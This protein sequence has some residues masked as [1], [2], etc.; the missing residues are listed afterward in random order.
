MKL[1]ILI[2]TLSFSILFSGCQIGYLLHVSYNHLAMLNT[3]VPV[4]EALSSTD[5]S[6]EQKKK[7]TLAQ[8]ARE[9]AFTDLGL[10]RTSSYSDFVDLKRKSVTYAV[11]ASEKWKLQSYMW[12]FPI[13][14]KAPYKGYYNE[15]LAN[16]EADEMKKLNYDVYVRGVSAFSTLGKMNDPLLSSM[17]R[18]S[19]HDLVNTIIHELVHS[20]LFIKSSIDF[21][22]R[23]AVF[24]ANK[25][26]EIYY[27]KKEGLQSKTL[28]QIKNENEDDTLFS[29]FITEELNR[30]KAW[31]EHFDH[32][33]KISQEEKEALRQKQ[34]EQIK[35]NF[36]KNL[37]EKLKTKSYSHF[38]TK[39]MN[40]ATLGNYNTYMKNLDSFDK[41]YKKNNS[42]IPTF[43]KKCKELE[44]TENPEQ[45]LE[46]WA[47]E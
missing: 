30:L 23:L 9:F 7:L 47:M 10:K 41:V 35:E 27:L 33:Q 24:V 45:E 20:T 17:L 18:Y 2:S 46:K 8:E 26:T 39:M 44:D 28:Q 12:N 40:N 43:L 3:K 38:T 13:I 37:S 16:K 29:K 34:F 19:D 36:K 22:E 15:E 6:E 11:M 31:Y 25:G 21:N 4:S 5:L 1:K 32:T 42:D 14:G